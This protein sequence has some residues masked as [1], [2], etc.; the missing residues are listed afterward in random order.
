[1]PQ[2]ATGIRARDRAAACDPLRYSPAIHVNQEGYAP[3][4]PKKAMI[5]YYLGDMGELDIPASSG[6]A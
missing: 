2:P 3:A 5:G 6:F 1:M 4:L